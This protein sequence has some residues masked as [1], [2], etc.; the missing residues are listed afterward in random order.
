MDLLHQA[1]AGFCK[2]AIEKE[3]EKKIKKITWEN[4]DL[5]GLA[6]GPCPRVV[7]MRK[8]HKD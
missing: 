8:F 1:I 4:K 2:V 6:L 5:H 7:S 3:K